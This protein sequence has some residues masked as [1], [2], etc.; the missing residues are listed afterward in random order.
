MVKHSQAPLTYLKFL[1]MAKA[2]RDLPAFPAMDDVEEKL[3]NAFAQAWSAGVPLTVVDAMNILSDTSP[4][5]AHRRLKALRKSGWI[6]LKQD[7]E[8]NRIKYV[9]PTALADKYFSKLE[10]C[11]KN[12]QK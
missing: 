11:L 3:L 7:D 12:A 8:D 6:D 2:I 1:N 4:A 10:D 9:V 5:T